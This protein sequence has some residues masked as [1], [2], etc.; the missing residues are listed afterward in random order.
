MPSF[1][2]MYV[3]E[4]TPEAVAVPVAVEDIAVHTPVSEAVAVA[5][6]VAESH[7]SMLP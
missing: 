6:A 7:P 1:E 5:L 2:L 3:F 4:K